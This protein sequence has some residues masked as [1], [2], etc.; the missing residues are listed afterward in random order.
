MVSFTFPEVSVL[1]K[2]FKIS[3]FSL[4]L[5]GYGSNLSVDASEASS[6]IK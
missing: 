4:P 5:S 3:I 1:E 6:V 2:C